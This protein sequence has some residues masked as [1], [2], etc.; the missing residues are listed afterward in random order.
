MRSRLLWTAVIGA[1]VLL[2][3]CGDRAAGPAGDGRY[4]RLALAPC[5]TGEGAMRAEAMCGILEVPEDRGAPGG[6][7]IALNIAVLPARNAAGLEP[8]FFLAGGPGQAATALAGHID[9][10]LREV[11]RSRD[12]VLV[13]QRGTGRSNPLDCVAAD[14][15]PLPFDA[16]RMS[17]PAAIAGYAQRCAAGLD[18]RADPRH[19]TTAAA[20]ADLDDVRA[21]LG[22]ETVDLVGGSYGT[23]VAQ[24]YAARYPQHVRSLVLDG[25]APNDLVIGAEFAHTFESA[26]RLQAAQCDETEGCRE[27]FPTDAP[28]QLRQVMDRL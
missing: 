8:V 20:I 26:L 14:G 17:D 21:A 25:V 6:R 16:T 10:A 3:G 5:A 1:S 11:R 4:G 12:V 22:A 7:R 13:D 18:G 19:Y 24:H 28:T 27:R 9:V 23:R 15:T 2:A